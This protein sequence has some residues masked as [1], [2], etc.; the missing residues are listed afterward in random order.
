MIE[1]IIISFLVK[2]LESLIKRIHKF[3]MERQDIQQE[4]LFWKGSN[5]QIDDVL[6]LGVKV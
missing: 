5:K 4:F 3:P 2:D 1:Q 6:V